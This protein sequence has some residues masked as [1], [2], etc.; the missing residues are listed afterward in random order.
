MPRLFIYPKK[1]VP[2]IF[3][4][5]DK[6]VSIGRLPDNDII[7]DDAYA[8]GHHAFIL[9]ATPSGYAIKDNLSKN[10]TFINGIRITE[11][12][13]L[14]RGD[15]ICIGSTKIFFDK[16]STTSVEMTDEMLPASAVQSVIQLKKI[17]P[18]IDTAT[19]RK[20]PAGSAELEKLKLDYRYFPVLT[21]VSQALILH[22]PI[23]ELLDEIMDLICKTLPMDRAILMLREGDPPDL[24]PKVVRIADPNLVAQKIQVSRCIIDIVLAE[25]SSVLTYDAQIDPRFRSS[26]SIIQ[27]NIHSAMCVPLWNN[28]A[29]IGVIYADRILHLERF[30]EEDL[31]LLTLLSNLAAVKIENAKL[32]QQAI[33]KE[34][35]D[36]ELALASQ[37][38]KDFLPKRNPECDS[39]DLAG[40]NQTC[41]QVGGDYY[42]FINIDDRRMAIIVADV[43][44]KGVSASLL[45]ASL[46]AAIYAELNP[47]YSLEKLGCRLN[48]FVHHSSSAS[49][50]ITFFLLELDRETGE[51][52]YLNAGHNPPLILTKDGQVKRLE[53]SGFCLGMFPSVKYEVGCDRL[54][55]GDL[56]VLYT[57]GITESRNQNKEEFGEE[58]L[59]EVVRKN[60]QL[61]AQKMIETVLVE[62]NKFSSDK[63]PD[64]DRTLVI[65]KRIAGPS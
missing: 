50:F 29:I 31:K 64:D 45:M 32:I 1:G 51:L 56:V 14:V 10:G 12:T 52:K 19:I 23:E 13:T 53:S 30:S 35:M 47:E 26:E 11:E 61:P 42:D 8:S 20:E 7:I 17:L 49:N 55:V 9:P 54:E 3:D 43:S 6:K 39:F 41:Y 62:V 44:G 58:R 59:I 22:K 2:F 24:I 60:M 38:Q 48:D 46:R 27:S 28:R 16:E 21:Q 34:K 5:L 33:E 57:D 37:I 18:S 40:Y 25:N 63:E 65:I 4:L 15:E 36:R